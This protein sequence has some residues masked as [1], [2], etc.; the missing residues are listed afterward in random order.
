MVTLVRHFENGDPAL[1]L[2]ALQ[3]LK[4][5]AEYQI[6]FSKVGKDFVS[7]EEFEEA[8]RKAIGDQQKCC[9]T[10][11]RV[12]KSEELLVKTC[13]RVLKEKQTQASGGFEEVIYAIRM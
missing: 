12:V 5:K 4:K 9:A 6:F 3:D 11:I 8:Y 7:E 13:K 1:T 2:S 10:F